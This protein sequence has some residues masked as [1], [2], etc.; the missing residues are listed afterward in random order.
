MEVV[1]RWGSGL[2]FLRSWFTPQH[3]DGSTL[4]SEI[5]GARSGY[6]QMYWNLVRLPEGSRI[7]R[8]WNP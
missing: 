6:L 2:L 8:K 5:R 4:V 3:M 1:I 7:P